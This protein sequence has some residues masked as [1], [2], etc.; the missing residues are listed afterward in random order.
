M[1]SA[2]IL[3]PHMVTLKSKQR[4]PLFLFL[5]FMPRYIIQIQRLRLKN[6]NKKG[7]R[8]NKYYIEDSVEE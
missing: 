4:Q 5:L 7:I 1:H 2:I 8:G 6:K 3:S